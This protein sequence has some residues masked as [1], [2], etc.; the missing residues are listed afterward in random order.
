MGENK[1][2]LGVFS[3]LVTFALVFAVAEYLGAFPLVHAELVL[4]IT[5]RVHEIPRGYSSLLVLIPVMFATVALELPVTAVVG[6]LSHKIA[7]S[8]SGGH[9]VSNTVKWMKV[10]YHFKTFFITVF[11]EE[12]FA[13]WF[14][15]G[16]L[17]KIPFLSG[18]GAFYCL[19]L[20]GN[21]VWALVHLSNFE[22]KSD[23]NPIRVLAQFVAGIFF[24][25]IFVKYG[26]LAAVLTHFMSNSILFAMNKVQRFNQ[27][28]LLIIAY[29][30]VCVI[31]SHSL[32]GR[33]LAEIQPWFAAH[34]TFVLPGWGFWD[35]LAVSI[36]IDSFLGLVLCLLAYDRPHTGESKASTGSFFIAA[37]II[38]PLVIGFMY[39]AYWFLGLFFADVGMRVLALTVLLC[40]LQESPSMSAVS[41]LFWSSLPGTYITICIFQALG[42][43]PA[44]G[45]TI[46]E[47]LVFLPRRALLQYDD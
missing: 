4:F 23:R 34:P 15:L 47:M 33:P 18:A 20:L 46:I 31:A 1:R 38:T 40:F 10:D 42:F 19:L 36:F 3:A 11:L 37:V 30:L 16:L 25:Y 2:A 43:W 22:K 7:G 39:L 27:I 14:F 21:G 8:H 24:S 6:M 45:Y 12:V 28:D 17:T 9:A 44:V 32:L 26:L 5:G 29:S 41:R 13:R 35:Y